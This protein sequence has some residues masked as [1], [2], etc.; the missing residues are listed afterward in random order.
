MTPRFLTW[1][2]SRGITESE[3]RDWGAAL[4][5]QM[6]NYSLYTLHMSFLWNIHVET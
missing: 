5:R 4:E 1:K 2:F 6:M 3:N